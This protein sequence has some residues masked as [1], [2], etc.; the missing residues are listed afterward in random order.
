MSFH[1]PKIIDAYM[2]EYGGPAYDEWIDL[3]R[4]TRA[5]KTRFKVNHKRFGVFDEG[6]WSIMDQVENLETE[7]EE[8]MDMIQAKKKVDPLQVRD[9]LSNY[10]LAVQIA[11]DINDWLDAVFLMGFV[12]ALV[13][14]PFVYFMIRAEELRKV[15]EQLKPLLEKAKR[16]AKEARIQKAL[17]ISVTIVTSILPELGV[18]GKLGLVE[19]ITTNGFKLTYDYLL[20]PKEP[21]GGKWGK[22]AFSTFAESV[23]KSKQI[24]ETAADVL[25][26]TSKGVKYVGW[27]QMLDKG[28]IPQA[29]ANLHQIQSLLD[30]AKRSYIN[31]MKLIDE[32]L[33]ALQRIKIQIEHAQ[34]K[35]SES[36]S[37]IRDEEEVFK[38][39][40][41]VTGYRSPIAWRILP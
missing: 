32:N 29:D 39:Q 41:E 40:I 28:E 23:Y 10:D 4:R 33:P 22:A 9:V 14:F 20:G 7:S 6:L 38:E 30:S 27:L 15:I 2:N 11:E 1:D 13:H 18:I 16:E 37:N 25:K 21:S 34:I 31:F 24:N 26:G 35:L 8:A 3:Q 17:D 12:N 19:K 5:V 36:R